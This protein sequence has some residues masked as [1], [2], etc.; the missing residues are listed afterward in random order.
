LFGDTTIDGGERSG[1]RISAGRWL[2]DC[3]QTG[4]E[5]VYF[6]VFDDTGSGDFFAQTGPVSGDPILARPFYDVDQGRENSQL[7][8]F[9]NLVDGQIDIS[10]SSEMHSVSALLRRHFR[11]GPRGR[12]DLIGGY[13]FFRYHESLHFQEDLVST[14][15]GGAAPI[16][17]GT[18]FD[19]FDHFEAEN[20]FHGGDLGITAEFYRDRLTLELLA[21]VALGNL[22]RRV[23]I[24]GETTIV[25][26]PPNSTSSENVGGL[27]ALSTNIGD[28]SENSFAALPEFG[29][30]V[31]LQATDHLAFNV[32]Y[33]LVM[34]NGVARTGE[35][36][37]RYVN[38]TYLPGQTPVGPARPRSLFNDNLADFWV[39]GVSFGA[40]LEY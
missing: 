2:D 26:P 33:T 12:I 15:T 19:I 36:I 27:L 3:Q 30:N 39:Q 23:R 35:Q 21:K 6:S 31:G 28:R 5:V 18:T 22:H 10:S 20:D 11:C 13:R 38:S 8:S 32:G 1:L 7:I 40:T 16:P 14:N 4:L 9:P 17:L 37:D 24:D 25:T 29:V 34:L